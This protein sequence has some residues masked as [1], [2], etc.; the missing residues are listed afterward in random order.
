MT[1]IAYLSRQ[2]EKKNKQ[3]G[4]RESIRIMSVSACL[5]YLEELIAVYCLSYSSHSEQH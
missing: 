3:C 2:V 5:S 1:S 4:A